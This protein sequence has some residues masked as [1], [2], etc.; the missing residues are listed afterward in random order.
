[1]S[2]SG[3][4][5]FL[6]FDTEFINLFLESSWILSI[7]IYTKLYSFNH[8]KTVGCKIIIREENCVKKFHFKSKLVQKYITKLSIFNSNLKLKLKIK[9]NFGCIKQKF[10]NRF[11][12]DCRKFVDWFMKISNHVWQNFFKI[13]I[14][15][16]T[17]QNLNQILLRAIVWNRNSTQIGNLDKYLNLF[18]KILDSK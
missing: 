1:M 6:L 8:Y 2:L 16:E 11:R 3:K 13:N 17:F 9:D 4:L 12:I 14:L 7:E 10:S 5:Y 18:I 15:K